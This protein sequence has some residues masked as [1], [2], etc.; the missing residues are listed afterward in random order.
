MARRWGQQRRPDRS[1]FWRLWY[2]SRIST[3]AS[4][5]SLTDVARSFGVSD[6]EN[7]RPFDA[8]TAK[9]LLDDLRTSASSG[10]PQ[11]KLFA[12]F[13]IEVAQSQPRGDPLDP[14]VTAGEVLLPADLAEFVSGGYSRPETA[15]RSAEGVAAARR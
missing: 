3:E 15:G 6:D 5:F 11:V 8:E 14:T 13:V 9:A 7:A 10:D 2:A 1:A 12:L 4:T